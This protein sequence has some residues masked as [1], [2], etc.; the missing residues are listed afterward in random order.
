MPKISTLLI[1]IAIGTTCIGA[2]TMAQVPVEKLPLKWEP[3][4]NL[5][6][7]DFSMYVDR[8]SMSRKQTE[9]S[10]TASGSFLLVPNSGA[11][12][13]KNKQGK[14]ISALSMVRTLAVDCKEGI[15]IPIIDEYFDT[16]SPDRDTKVIGVSDYTKSLPIDI[17]PKNSTLFKT[18]CPKY[19]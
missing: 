16:K 11:M 2:V 19:I 3:I 14:I 13:F 17:L 12:Q 4:P 10:D 6:I 5:S 8:N 9:N 15:A 18:L 7:D 1:A